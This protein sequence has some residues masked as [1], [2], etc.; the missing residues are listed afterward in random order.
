MTDKREADRVIMNVALIAALVVLI[1]NGPEMTARQQFG[2]CW[3]L[4]VAG[5]H[6]PRWRGKDGQ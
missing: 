5:I 3:L 6:H 4:I 2:T 1:V